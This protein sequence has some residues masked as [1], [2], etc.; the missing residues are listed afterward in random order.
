MHK[1]TSKI[2]KKIDFIKKILKK[3]NN[4]YILK[5]K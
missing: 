1:K 4:L 5:K 3:L 2:M